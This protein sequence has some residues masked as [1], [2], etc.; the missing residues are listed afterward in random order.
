LDKI[1][2]MPIIKTKLSLVLAFTK[3]AP[4][5]APSNHQKEIVEKCT[6]VSLYPIY[7]S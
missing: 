1:I 7:P 4:P 6:L 5:K 2:D 3:G